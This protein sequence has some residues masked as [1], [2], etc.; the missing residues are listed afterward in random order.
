MVLRIVSAMQSGQRRPNSATYR[1][2]IQ[3]QG[4]NETV[5]FDVLTGKPLH[6]LR[7]HYRLAAHQKQ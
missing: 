2:E 4:E 1:F 3:L 7:R 5:F 6:H